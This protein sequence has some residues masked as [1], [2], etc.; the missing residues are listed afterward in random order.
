MQ[1]RGY[2]RNIFEETERMN[3]LISTLLNFSRLSRKEITKEP[4]D[5]S[6]IAGARAAELRLNEPERQVKCII[7]K[8]ERHGGRVWAEGVVGE[9]A[10]IYFT[11]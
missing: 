5:I 7:A 8:G 11:L 9:G 2:V 3:Q 6:H 10:A 4:I 1:G